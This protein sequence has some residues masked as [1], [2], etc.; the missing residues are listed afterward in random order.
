M[1]L[2][3]NLIILATFKINIERHFL[4][5]PR[6]F[7]YFSKHS[8]SKYVKTRELKVSRGHIVPP[9]LHL[10]DIRCKCV[11]YWRSH[12]NHTEIVV[13]EIMSAIASA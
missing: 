4:P 8:G 12:A 11:P 9:L 2:N 1:Y 7:I 5:I 10:S 13:V 6:I 3:R